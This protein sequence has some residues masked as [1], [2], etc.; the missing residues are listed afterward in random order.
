MIVSIS[1]ASR[2]TGKSR[3]TLY[4]MKNDGRLSFMTSIDNK[5][6]GIDVSELLRVFP[7]IRSPLVDRQPSQAIEQRRTSSETDELVSS[8]KEQ[9]TTLKLLIEEKDTRISM[10]VHIH[11]ST[12]AEP[13]Q[14]A[15]T[16][17]VKS[18]PS[19]RRGFFDRLAD[20]LTEALK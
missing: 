6:S 5:V 4:T 17:P 10:L 3:Q 19:R 12:K 2:L 14:P 15:T 11:S 16:P 8:L 18:E 1:E 9:I 7:H 13:S 20:G